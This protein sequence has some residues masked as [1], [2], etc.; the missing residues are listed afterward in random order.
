MTFKEDDSIMLGAVF[1]IL[2]PLLILSVPLLVNA[3]EQLELQTLPG[4]ADTLN[5]T[6]ND[7]WDT[8]GS[9]SADMDSNGD[10]IY[11]LKQST[12]TWTSEIF[13]VPR[14]RVLD[15][16]YEAL[17]EE[18]T[19]NINIS[20]W[21]DNP[22]TTAPD[23]YSVI[24]M[25]SGTFTEEIGFA[26]YNYFE[27]VVTMTENQN[28]NNRRPRLEYLSLQYEIVEGE[29][30]GI[31]EGMKIVLSYVLLGFGIVILAIGIL[32]ALRIAGE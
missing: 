27:A 23:N 8:E 15:V 3:S 32:K 22:T 21:T 17:M 12:G 13:N 6:I 2:I 30:E 18:G 4:V 1:F 28:S 10:E 9:L 24:N 26:E 19:G 7:E 11:P 29:Q 31:S 25:S 16:T 5:Y 20:V 14:N